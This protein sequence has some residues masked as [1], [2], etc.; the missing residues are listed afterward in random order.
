LPQSEKLNEDGSK[1]YYPIIE[2][3]PDIKDAIQNAVLAAWETPD[4][5]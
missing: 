4:A 5:T 2:V 3:E 1:S